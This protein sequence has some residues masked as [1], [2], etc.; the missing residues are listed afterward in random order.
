MVKGLLLAALRHV[1]VLVELHYVVADE[2]ASR[3]AGCM[4]CEGASGTFDDALAGL[5]VLVAGDE[6]G[7]KSLLSEEEEG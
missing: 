7:G 6:D 5:V 1:L 2:L 3:G 4:M